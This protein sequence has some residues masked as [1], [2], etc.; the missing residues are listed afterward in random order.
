MKTET[1][2]YFIKL[3][4]VVKYATLIYITNE[5]YA[6]LR[7]SPIA[8]S[9]F[10]KDVLKYQVDDDSPVI[11]VE[12]SIEI[13]IQHGEISD[14]ILFYIN[15]DKIYNNSQIQHLT[16]TV[17]NTPWFNGKNVL[18]ICVRNDVEFVNTDLLSAVKTLMQLNA[19]ENV[20]ID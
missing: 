18:F 12:E 9:Q 10:K 17:K 7:Q 19:M 6:Q 3:T 4:G 1:L 13:V 5:Y 8:L 14:T 20:R 16:N 15:V 11:I 2:E